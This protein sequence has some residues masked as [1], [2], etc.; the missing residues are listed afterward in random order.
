MQL[1]CSNEIR[2]T[3]AFGNRIEQQRH[4]NCNDSADADLPV[5]LLPLIAPD[6]AQLLNHRKKN[7]IL[8]W[9]VCVP[10]RLAHKNS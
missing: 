5:E 4:S 3:P 8:I 6:C 1:R 7:G 9:I 10:I 2:Q